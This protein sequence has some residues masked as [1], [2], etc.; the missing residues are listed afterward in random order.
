MFY[1]KSYLVKYHCKY[2]KG[3][4]TWI[5]KQLIWVNICKILWNFMSHQILLVCSY[6]LPSRWCPL[7]NSSQSGFS[8]FQNQAEIWKRLNLEDL[9]HYIDVIQHSFFKLPFSNFPIRCKAL[10]FEMN[11]SDIIV[12]LSPTPHKLKWT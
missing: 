7:L 1:S 6:I 9:F 3:W 10:C 11:F 8:S 5:R 2:N 12:N 4:I